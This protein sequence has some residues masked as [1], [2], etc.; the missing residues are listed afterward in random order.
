MLI[1]IEGLDGVGKTEVAKTISRRLG[2]QYIDKPMKFLLE[3]SDPADML[4]YRR[5]TSKVNA[6]E[7]P[8]PRLLFYAIGSIILR[9]KMQ[10]DTVVDRY[11][12][13]NY[14]NNQC[15]LADKFMDLAIQHA[16]APDLTFV[17]YASP[18]VRRNRMIARNPNDPD[19]HSVHTN[20]TLY[21]DMDAFLNAHRL[22]YEFI[23]TST[24]SLHQVVDA[25]EKSIRTVS[26]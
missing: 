13:S 22:P 2:F 17:L 10:E 3:E 11:F 20:D 24:M 1:A 8:F 4:I 21:D 19:I 18:D 5:V 15:T 6:L 9:E 12:L 16:G 23:D 26:S 25:V 7:D 14:V